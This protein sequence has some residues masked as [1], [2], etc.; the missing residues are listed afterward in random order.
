MVWIREWIL[1]KT[2]ILA[3][4]NLPVETFAPQGTQTSVLICQKRTSDQENTTADYDIFMAIP[5][6]IGWDKRKAPLFKMDSEGK[7]ELDGKG[8][9]MVNDHVAMVSSVF[10]DWIRRKGIR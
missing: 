3:S 1:R 2:Y 6:K 5:E 8:Q 10:K 9:P 4:V 7:I